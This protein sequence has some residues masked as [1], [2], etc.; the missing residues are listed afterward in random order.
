MALRN[1]PVRPWMQLPNQH[2]GSV[3][4]PLQSVNWNRADSLVSAQYGHSNEYLQISDHLIAP[5][6]EQKFFHGFEGATGIF[7]R[8]EIDDQLGKRQ[9]CVGAVNVLLKKLTM[10][11]LVGYTH[12][13]SFNEPDAKTVVQ[14]ILPVS[15]HCLKFGE[16]RLFCER[17]VAETRDE[18]EGQ[19]DYSNEQALCRNSAR[20]ECI[21]TDRFIGTLTLDLL[22]MRRRQHFL[23]PGFWAKIVHCLHYRSDRALWECCGMTLNE[24]I[25]LA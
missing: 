17:K 21:R 3:K 10:F 19:S 11:V 4:L 15:A 12:R 7:L 9:I 23:P 13:D 25:T 22:R 20:R 24:V 14:L 2:T 16:S 8:V 5:P 6:V 18:E 1:A